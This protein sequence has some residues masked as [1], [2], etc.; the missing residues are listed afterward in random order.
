[1]WEALPGIGVA[2]YSFWAATYAFGSSPNY[3]ILRLYTDSA[4]GDKVKLRCLGD[5]AC[6]VTEYWTCSDIAPTPG[7][8]YEYTVYWDLPF[9]TPNGRVDCWWDG[10]QTVHDGTVQTETN[11]AYWNSYRYIFAGIWDWHPVW[12]CRSYQKLYTDDLWDCS[13]KVV[14]A[15]TPTPWPTPTP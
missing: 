3:E 15:V 12:G 7:Q 6:D 9:N 8:W 14:G 4:D 5:E 2:P 11:P 10:V 1:M 13:C